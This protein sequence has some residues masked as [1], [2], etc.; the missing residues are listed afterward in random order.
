MSRPAR[1]RGLKRSIRDTAHQINR[2][3]PARARGLK[4]ARPGTLL[5]HRASRPARARGLK[6]VCLAPSWLHDVSRPARARG[7]KL[8][9]LILVIS[10]SKVA[11]RA[12]A[13]IETFSWTFYKFATLSRAPR[14]RV[15]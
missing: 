6:L 5:S 15:D 11:P 10:R 13:W 8:H 1:A 4:L 12:G 2:S 9:I 3:R 7:L 14:G